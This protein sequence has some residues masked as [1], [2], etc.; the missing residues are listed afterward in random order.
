MFVKRSNRRVARGIIIMVITITYIFTS[1]QR[2]GYQYGQSILV[3]FDFRKEKKKNIS[4][5][6]NLNVIIICIITYCPVGPADKT[7]RRESGESV[8]VA[9]ALRIFP[10]RRSAVIG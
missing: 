5:K 7:I 1:G 10:R 2:N 8:S 6:P 9:R 3:S 4:I